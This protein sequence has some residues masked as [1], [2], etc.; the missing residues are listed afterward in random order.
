MRITRRRL[1]RL[2][3]EEL[4]RLIEQESQQDI[5]GSLMD[6][7]ALEDED[8]ETEQQT[9]EPEVDREQSHLSGAV[10]TAVLSQPGRSPFG[11]MSQPVEV[12][13]YER[14]RLPA[15]V[16]VDAQVKRLKSDFPR[17]TV[18]M[19]EAPWFEKTTA[20]D[21]R[22]EALQDNIALV[23]VQLNPAGERLDLYSAMW[24]KGDDG[25]VVEHDG[26]YSSSQ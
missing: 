4:N 12:L 3:N 19:G 1:R 23:H 24:T 22:V 20:D 11:T 6:E 7:F 10:K 8:A 14:G 15:W 26:V 5:F 2:I 25:E 18:H 21:A 9:S 17:A 13:V 16:D